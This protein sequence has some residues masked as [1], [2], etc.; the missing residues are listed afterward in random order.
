M[1]PRDINIGEPGTATAPSLIRVG[2]RGSQ[3]GQAVWGG[4]PETAVTAMPLS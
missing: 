2:G 3:K 4:S 1:R